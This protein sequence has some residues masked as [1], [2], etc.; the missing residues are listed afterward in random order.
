M[1]T[2]NRRDLPHPILKPNGTDYVPQSFFR[3]EPVAI[4]RSV[5]TQE[6]TVAVR[7]SQNS[8]GLN[9]LI[10]LGSAQFQCL[11][12]CV[13]TLLRE[14]Y[15]STT[16]NHTI[17]LSSTQYQ[18]QVLLRPFIIATV[19]IPNF[20]CIDWS[21]SIQKLLPEGAAIPVGSILAIG[22]ETSFDVNTANEQESYIEITPSQDVD[23]SRFR[24]D[25]SGERIVIEINP[26]D[27]PAIDRIRQDE[28]LLQSLFPSMYQRAVEEA[29]RQH[30]KEDHAGKRWAVRIAET[31]AEHQL[32]TDDS[33]LLEA[34]S[35]DY[36][37][38]I[39]Q[40]PLARIISSGTGD[41]VRED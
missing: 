1:T 30:R 7:Y 22:Q 39:M 36:A 15:R 2:Y 31:L 24:I 29:V 13:A 14:L 40:N 17:R 18:G 19:D 10:E 3:C 38:Q 4:R 33:D 12:E 5:Q 35:L 6:I 23:S 16:R 28:D 32:E 25:L 27:K 37:Q 8:E 11:T 21:P 26:D 9:K 20:R 34:N 41:R